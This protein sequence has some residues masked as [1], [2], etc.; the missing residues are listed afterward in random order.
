MFWPVMASN[1]GLGGCWAERFGGCEFV[2]TLPRERRFRFDLGRGAGTGGT[3]GLVCKAA[4]VGG[5]IFVNQ[6]RDSTAS[7]IDWAVPVNFGSRRFFAFAPV[8]G[9]R[10]R[11]E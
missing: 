6:K 7:I 5:E 1:F 2:P 3:R 11:L 10:V 8:D 4:D 9:P